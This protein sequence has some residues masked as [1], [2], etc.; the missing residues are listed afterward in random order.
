MSALPTLALPTLPAPAPAP[1]PARAPALAPARAPAHAH[2]PAPASAQDDRLFVLCLDT[3]AGMLFGTPVENNQPDFYKALN[4]LFKQLVDFGF[5]VVLISS[6]SPRVRNA[7]FRFFPPE[8]YAM[9]RPYISKVI[10][11][12]SSLTQESHDRMV[13]SDWYRKRILE[14]MQEFNIDKV[15][16]LSCIEDLIGALRM[17]NDEG[18][19]SDA[20]SGIFRA[21]Q[22]ISW[23][24]AI[25]L[26]KFFQH[27]LEDISR[28]MPY[29]LFNIRSWRI[30]ADIR[31]RV[32][33]SASASSAVSTVSTVSASAVSAVSTVSAS[34]VTH[35][36]LET[37]PVNRKKSKGKPKGKRTIELSSVQTRF[38]PR[39]DKDDK[40]D[41]REDDKDDKREDD[42]DGNH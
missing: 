29:F 24:E 6:A 5:K 16:C 7:L 10:V 3:A 2:A 39:D 25:N 26:I 23:C 40:D 28:R 30:A 38:R 1:A 42:K 14:V 33:E 17:L 27:H 19:I 34:D 31:Q 9:Y 12:P 8:I 41:K 22:P 11:H 36:W 13:M 32:N 15:L 4:S 35:Y 21:E 37:V 20:R 18:E